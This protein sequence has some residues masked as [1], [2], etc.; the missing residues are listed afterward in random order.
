MKKI[1]VKLEKAQTVKAVL[2]VLRRERR[3][4][5]PWHRAMQKLRVVARESLKRARN[6]HQCMKILASTPISGFDKELRNVAITRM[7]SFITFNAYKCA[8][9]LAKPASEA[10]RNALDGM[11]ATACTVEEF[12]IVMRLAPDTNKCKAEAYGRIV[13]LRQML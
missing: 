1:D 3:G 12:E 5:D 6:E 2:K 4:S 13:Q 9:I 8:Y 11:L 7:L 10:E